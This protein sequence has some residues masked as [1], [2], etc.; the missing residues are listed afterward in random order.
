[1]ISV[2]SICLLLGLVVSVYVDGTGRLRAAEGVLAAA[3]FVRIA[4]S[5]TAA[6]TNAAS[7]AVDGNT[8]TFSLT[9][10]VAGS[11]WTAELGR[12]YALRRI[13]ILGRLVCG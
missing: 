9:A 10:D 7:R 5:S 2:R 1:M 6:A 4:Q 12:P 13:E 11:F 8:N 3:R